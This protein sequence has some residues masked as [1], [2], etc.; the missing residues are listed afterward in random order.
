MLKKLLQFKDQFRALLEVN[1]L[2]FSNYIWSLKTPVP[3]PDEAF[4]EDDE[5]EAETSQADGLDRAPLH[6]PE[7]FENELQPR[8]PRRTGRPARR[9]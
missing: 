8:P 3:Q 1:K 9:S 2:S 5:P 4:D 7:I 6:I